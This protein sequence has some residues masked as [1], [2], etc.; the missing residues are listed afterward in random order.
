MQKSIPTNNFRLNHPINTASS[1]H[2]LSM[3][4]FQLNNNI[5]NNYKYGDKIHKTKTFKMNGDKNYQSKTNS[6]VK[7]NAYL[8]TDLGKAKKGFLF[9]DNK[10]NNF[11]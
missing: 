4:S 3:Q 6:S 1:T 9:E 10:K 8:M 2:N 5:Y 11:Y 7:Y